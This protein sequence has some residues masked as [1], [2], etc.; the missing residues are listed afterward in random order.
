TNGR[1]FRYH[2]FQREA[3]ETLIYLWEVEKV[4]KRTELLER[5]ARDLNLRLPTH[6]DFVRYAVKMATGSGK[7]KVMSLAVVWQYLNAARD[8]G[9]DYAK[10]FLV[11]A[12]NVIVYERLRSDFEGG[13]IFEADPLIPKHMRIFWLMDCVMR[14]DGERAPSDGLLFLTNIQQLYE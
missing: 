8:E 14:G 4:R 7:T 3:I 1:Q 6:D 11:V 2:D 9:S 5:Y 10:T 12:P 13:H